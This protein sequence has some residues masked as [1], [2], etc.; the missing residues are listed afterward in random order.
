LVEHIKNDKGQFIFVSLIFNDMSTFTTNTSEVTYPSYQAGGIIH[1][2]DLMNNMLTKGEIDT[3]HQFIRVP[4]MVPI[5][6]IGNVQAGTALFY[7][8][9]YGK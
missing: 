3:T 2:N 8:H 7:N 5:D 4:I 1:I 9:N 6:G